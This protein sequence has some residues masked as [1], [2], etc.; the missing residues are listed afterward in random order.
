LLLFSAIINYS[1]RPHRLKIIRFLAKEAK[2]EEYAK[3]RKQIA[4]DTSDGWI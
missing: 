2:E 1:F 3:T 4:S